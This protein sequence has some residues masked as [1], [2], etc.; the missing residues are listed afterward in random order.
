MAPQ[1]PVY[2]GLGPTLLAVSWME[3]SITTILIALRAYTKVKLVSRGGSWALFW[4]VCAWV[5]IPSFGNTKGTD[6]SIAGSRSVQWHIAHC[7]RSIWDGQSSELS[8]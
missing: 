2:G 8:V 7:C 6:R 1:G 4:A 5:S 3:F